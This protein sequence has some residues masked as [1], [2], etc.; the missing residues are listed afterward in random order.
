LDYETN[1][2]AVQHL[3]RAINE[4]KNLNTKSAAP[5]NL[6]SLTKVAA[7]EISLRI[8]AKEKELAAET[9]RRGLIVGTMGAVTTFA[10]ACLAR[11]LLSLPKEGWNEAMEAM[12]HQ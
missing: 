3:R 4:F 8:K 9:T 2:V 5:I 11:G 6:D 1:F 7:E 12:G 10:A